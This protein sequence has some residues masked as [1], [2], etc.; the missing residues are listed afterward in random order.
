MWI[1][2]FL[3]KILYVALLSSLNLTLVVGLRWGQSTDRTD[4]TGRVWWHTDLAVA[5]A[6][7]MDQVSV[8][9]AFLVFFQI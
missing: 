7:I 3:G 5:L 6:P 8:T 1:K 2:Q 4:R 9:G